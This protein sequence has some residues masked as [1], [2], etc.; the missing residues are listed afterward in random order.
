VWACVIL[1]RSLLG[2]EVGEFFV[3]FGAQRWFV[4]DGDV[5]VV[6]GVFAGEQVDRVG[7]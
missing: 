4:G 7:E 1:E 6:V 2:V 5:D 3:F